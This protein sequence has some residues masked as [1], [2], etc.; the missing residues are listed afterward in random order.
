M[1]KRLLFCVILYEIVGGMFIYRLW[2]R[3]QR[4]GIVE[5][6]LLSI[7][8]LFPFL[9]LLFYGFLRTSPDT[10]SDELPEHYTGDDGRGDSG[11]N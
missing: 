4:P 9:G 3:K 2:T 10:H 8:L 1:N 7:A 6:C 5:R 11:H